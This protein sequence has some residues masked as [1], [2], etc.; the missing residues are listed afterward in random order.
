MTRF[1]G[2]HPGTRQTRG[3]QHVKPATPAEQLA[4]MERELASRRESYPDTHWMVQEQ[5]GRIAE[6]KI[7]VG[8]CC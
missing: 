3:S 5:I 4:A 1:W 7:E 6:L 8:E 2:N